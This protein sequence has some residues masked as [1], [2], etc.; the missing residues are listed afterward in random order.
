MP[1]P[2]RDDAP[3]VRLRVTTGSPLAEVFLIDHAFAL[4]ERGIGELECVVAPGVYNVK[5]K[6]GDAVA[7]QLM[8]LDGDRTVHLSRALTIGSAAP[9]ERTA[10]TREDDEELARAVSGD[11]EVAPGH[12]EILLMGRRWGAED[13]RIAPPALTLGDGD[14]VRE[15]S[16]QQN[17]HAIARAFDVEPGAHRLRW[18]DHAGVVAEQAVPA[19]EGWQTQVFVLEDAVAPDGPAGR[20]P[21]GRTRVSILMG[22]R[23]FDPYEDQLR[24]VEAARTALADDRKVASDVVGAIV[25]DPSR[26]PML[27]LYG[28][29]LMLLARDAQRAGATGAG[30]AADVAFGQD[31]FDAIVATLGE[32]LGPGH[33]DVVALSTQTAAAH[34]GLA[35]WPPV[36]AP[37]MLWRSWALLVAASN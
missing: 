22:R 30:P 2:F 17:R 15:L 10:R 8:L 26:N 7:E 18:A 11:A 33:P 16:R 28:A 3:D 12:A 25:A 19:V 21:I 13:D 31:R 35:H 4:Q 32:L 27:M 24:L 34:G 6:L 9:L 23:G 20:V 36:T 37:P 29:H 1:S 14:P 5:A